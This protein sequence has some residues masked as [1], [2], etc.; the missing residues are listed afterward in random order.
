M[1]ARMSNLMITGM[2]TK[3][4]NKLLPL[5]KLIVIVPDDDFIKVLTKDF[6][7]GDTADAGGDG[8]NRQQAQNNNSISKPLSRMLNYVM[9]EYECSLSAYREYLPSKSVR[10][11]QPYLLWIQAPYHDH[12]NNNSAHFKFNRCL[13]EMT[14]LH[15]NTFSLMLKRVWDP[16]NTNFFLKDLLRYTA[17]GLSAYWEAVDH[18]VRYF[19]SVLLKKQDKLKRKSLQSNDPDP[20]CWQNP[21]YNK[22]DPEVRVNY[23][24]LPAPPP[25]R[26]DRY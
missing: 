25:K 18:T 22:T 8:D 7:V 2:E 4:N 10:Y 17:E 20:F 13:D 24:T 14:K 26:W 19:D 1:L 15:I 9:T 3:F 21:Q 5:L 12:F 23:R 16:K 11:N 6:D